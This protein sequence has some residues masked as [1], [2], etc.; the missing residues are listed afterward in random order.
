MGSLLPFTI[1]SLTHCGSLSGDVIGIRSKA[2][3]SDFTGSSSPLRHCN[4]DML[5]FLY[6]YILNIIIHHK[7]R[8]KLSK[9]CNLI[10]VGMNMDKIFG[11]CV[12][13]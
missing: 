7:A 3:R 4:L 11:Y 6:L 2:G 10:V 1:V 5:H 8:Q 9:Y 13:C 12:V